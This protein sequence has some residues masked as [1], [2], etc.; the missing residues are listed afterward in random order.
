MDSVVLYLPSPV[1]TT[2]IPE[3]TNVATGAKVALVAS[4]SNDMVCLAWKVV[5]DHR[6]GLITYCR[7]VSGQLKAGSLLVNTSQQ[8]SPKERLNRLVLLRA[9]DMEQVPSLSAG[10]IGAIIGLKHISTGDT[11]MES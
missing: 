11:L 8:S 10:N 9:Q 2:R 1:D 7:V 6:M 5:H 4:D 3:G